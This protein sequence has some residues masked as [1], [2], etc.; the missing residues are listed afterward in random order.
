MYDPWIDM[1]NCFWFKKDL[2]LISLF[3]VDLNILFLFLLDFHLYI[4]LVY[5]D[6]YSFEYI[7]SQMS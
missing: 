4:F 6:K 7:W 1:V 5:L 3:G 2:V